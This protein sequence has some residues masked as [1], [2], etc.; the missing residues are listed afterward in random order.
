MFNSH[1][2]QRITEL[3]A[4]NENLQKQYNIVHD[5]LLQRQDEVVA[6]QRTLSGLRQEPQSK[7]PN[8]FYPDFK[9]KVENVV[10][11]NTEGIIL[12]RIAEDIADQLADYLEGIIPSDSDSD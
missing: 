12:G 8:D 9:N 4:A 3:E 11:F 6:L 7:L 2:K 1:L 5:L 10:N